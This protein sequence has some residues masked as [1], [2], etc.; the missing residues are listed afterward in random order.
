MSRLHF[1]DI[2]SCECH[3][4][5]EDLRGRLFIIIGIKRV[6]EMTEYGGIWSLLDIQT[7]IIYP[8][9]IGDYL[10]VWGI[11]SPSCRVG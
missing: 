4:N 3:L 2:V 5:G 9:V 11:V 7:N 6:G 10:S 1:G 8:Q